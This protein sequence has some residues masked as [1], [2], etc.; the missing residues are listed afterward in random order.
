MQ[1]IVLAIVLTFIICILCLDDAPLQPCQYQV[2]LSIQDA[3][4]EH[5]EET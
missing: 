5:G 1:G 4:N 2:N 3:K